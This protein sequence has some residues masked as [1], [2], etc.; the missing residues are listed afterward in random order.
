MNIHA[1]RTGRW[2][3][4]WAAWQTKRP[5]LWSYGWTRRMAI[6]RA[7]RMTESGI[8]SAR[9]TSP[10]RPA[11]RIPRPPATFTPP[12]RAASKREAEALEALPACAQCDRIDVTAMGDINPVFI[13]NRC[14]E[15]H[16]AARA[17]A[18]QESLQHA[19]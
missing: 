1:H 12:T 2:S 18:K 4:R 19:H 8:T 9:P 14:T 3:K 7:A 13:L 16:V 17:V 11:R 10:L 6:R 15:C 5:D